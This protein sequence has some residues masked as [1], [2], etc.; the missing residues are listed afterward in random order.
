MQPSSPQVRKF[1]RWCKEK[2]C[3]ST[4][5]RGHW[6]RISR[7]SEEP[8]GKCVSLWAPGEESRLPPCSEVSAARGARKQQASPFPL[9]WL[10]GFRPPHPIDPGYQEK[11][12]LSSFQGDSGT[13]K[14]ILSPWNALSCNLINI[15]LSC[16]KFIVRKILNKIH[17]P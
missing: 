10:L 7:G 12:I 5:N 16:L 11:Q 1:L 17:H 13:P 14:P 8:N 6:A 9:S 2:S 15:L 3:G 4:G